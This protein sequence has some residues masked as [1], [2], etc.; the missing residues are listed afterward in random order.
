MSGRS[1]N[2]DDAL[3]ELWRHRSRSGSPLRLSWGDK[4][5]LWW[6]RRLVVTARVG[7]GIDQKWLHKF[8]RCGRW[9]GCLTAGTVVLANQERR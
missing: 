6:H 4:W 8:G 2:A 9:I 5:C 3:S 7:T 1:L